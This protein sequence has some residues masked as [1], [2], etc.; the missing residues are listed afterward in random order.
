[1]KSLSRRFL[2]GTTLLM[3]MFAFV[4]QWQISQSV[5]RSLTRADVAA[6]TPWLVTGLWTLLFLAAIY[7]LYYRMV[8]DRVRQIATR[9]NSITKQFGHTASARLR[10]QEQDPIDLLVSS[11]HTLAAQL[12][13][14][15]TA[16]EMRL[17]ERTSTLERELAA[18]RQLEIDIRDNDHHIKT[19]LESL[20]TGVLLIDAET[21]TITEANSSIAESIGLPLTEIVGR[22]C[23]DFVCPSHVGQC[24][25][26]DMHQ[27]I[28]NCERI[29]VRE[30]GSRVPILK[31]V[32]PIKF[33]GRTHLLENIVDI[34]DR[35]RAE[36][37]LRM[38]HQAV[39]Q[40]S[41][42]IVIT[43][44]EGTIVYVN[45]RYCE[46]TGYSVEESLGQN[47]R[48]LKSG[49]QDNRVY[50]EL[51]QTISAGKQ[52]SGE[53]YNRRRDGSL[54]WEQVSI[55]PV[56]DDQGMIANYLA[57]KDDITGI[58]R[59]KSA[60]EHSTA[61]PAEKN[62]LLTE[63]AATAEKANQANP[64]FL[65][66]MSHEL[67]MPLHGILSF[68]SF[69]IE[70]SRRASDDTL[71]EY[72][73]LISD[74][75][76]SLLALLN[77]LLDLARLESGCTEPVFSETDV[78]SLALSVVDECEALLARRNLRVESP[79][80]A[81]PPRACVDA[82]QIKQVFRNL[83]TN[84][85][86][87]SPDGSVIDVTFDTDDEEVTVHVADRGI[88]IPER[89]T[90]GIFD[91][92]IQSSKTRTSDGGAGLGLAI[93]REIITGHHGTIWAEHRSGGGAVLSFTL[94]QAGMPQ[95]IPASIS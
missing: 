28:D 21:H 2:V 40:A 51:W 89:E 73:E 39:E 43:D 37:K 66:N 38:L 46:Q 79:T 92:V 15:H 12:N 48:M 90:E 55:S 63:L 19:I 86:T 70:K 11:F 13:S 6:T 20:Q 44:P 14:L 30:D 32:V 9:I 93:C 76:E 71:T 56:F 1:M 77:D 82:R 85:I 62:A 35:K 49:N 84:S 10:E 78:Q 34:S 61:D 58:K 72:F 75:G 25:I 27:C 83:L 52:W 23:H 68:A 87:F 81:V 36:S 80:P 88:G 8:D 67:R 95:S 24:P 4:L 65:A 59:A 3:G 42:S 54:F 41:S 64:Q 74:N 60:L 45:P 33:G 5:R 53:L 91:K 47:P 69:G 29:L 31:T 16:L 22:T 57:V 7:F 94:P 26:T 18:K 50:R 17:Q